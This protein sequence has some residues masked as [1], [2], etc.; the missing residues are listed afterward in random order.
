VPRSGDPIEST[1]TSDAEKFRTE[2]SGS[3][4]QKLLFY[5]GW[6]GLHN[7]VPETGFSVNHR[8]TEGW[9]PR[10]EKLAGDHT[11]TTL[12]RVPQETQP[13]LV[14]FRVAGKR[15]LRPILSDNCSRATAQTKR[16]A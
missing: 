9:F 11:V 8:A 13:A 2:A 3:L 1:Q 10:V 12:V 16:C 14:D 15:E 4:L 6:A 5:F 7:E